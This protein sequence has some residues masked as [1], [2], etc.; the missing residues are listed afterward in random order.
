MKL[1]R[2][3]E[4]TTDPA[5]GALY[6]GGDIAFALLAGAPETREV[7]VYRVDFTAGARNR[8]H[9]HTRDQILIAVSG[10]GIIADA[11]GEQVMRPGDTVTVPAG[12]P[13]WHGA[14]A[15]QAFSHLTV[16]IPGDEIEIVDTD[17]RGAWG[18]LPEGP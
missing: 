9:I 17:A 15:E 12:H 14:T 10:R 6:V 3:N 13:H 18:A 4:A 11:E 5:T 16:A 8:V 2:G 1:V 7:E